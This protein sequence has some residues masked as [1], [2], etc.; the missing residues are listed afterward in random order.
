MD[1]IYQVSIIIVNYNT[2]QILEACILSIYQHT[3]NISFEIIVV[4]N[5]STDDSVEIIHRKFPEVKLI[6]S[7]INLGFGKANNLGVKQC[8]GEYLFFLNSDTLLIHNAIEVLYQ[9]MI[10]NPKA[11]ISG[12]NL[13]TQQ[14]KPLHSFYHLPSIW[15]EFKSLY[16]RYDITQNHN[17][18][19]H[20]LI[21]GYITGA[22]LMIAKDIFIKSG[23]FDPSFFMYYEESDLAWRI[24]KSG[25]LIY[26][27]PQAKII[28]LQG[29]SSPA[30]KILNTHYMFSKFLYF[31]KIFGS[32]IPPVIKALHLSKCIV[33]LAFYSIVRKKDR[34]IYWKHRYKA[35]HDV[36]KKY[37]IQKTHI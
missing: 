30:Q 2:R 10:K 25:Y 16:S 20:P 15:K 13:Y 26:S 35:I 34:R 17:F 5:A 8:Q 4:D 18:T 37:T 24:Q 6:S 22:D 27:V 29:M 36:Y 9:F 21:V 12:G 33:G 11:G 32:H 7:P 23:G 28:H 19:G 14:M 3:H 31:D 1:Y